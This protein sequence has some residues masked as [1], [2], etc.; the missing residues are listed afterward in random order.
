MKN[1]FWISNKHFKSVLFSSLL[2]QNYKTLDHI[3]VV[4][5]GGKIISISV[6][7]NIG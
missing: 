7:Q 3:A 2:Q 1:T 6:V 4:A 5:A